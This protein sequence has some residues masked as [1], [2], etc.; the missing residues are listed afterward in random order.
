MWSMLLPPRPL[1]SIIVSFDSRYGMYF[2]PSAR[3]LTVSA[4]LVS[5][6]LILMPSFA[7][8]PT[9]PVFFMP[10]DPARSTRLSWAKDLPRCSTHC[11]LICSS[12]CDRDD[13]SFIFV[14]AVA[15]MRLP[16]L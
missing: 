12:A 10:S 4:S 7:F 13:D 11:T 9:A 2:D 6:R 14:E 1:A 3:H 5:E 15:R 16:A 8:A